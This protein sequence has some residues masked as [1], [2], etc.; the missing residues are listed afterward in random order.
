MWVRGQQVISKNEVRLHCLS[1]RRSRRYAHILPFR[2]PLRLLST[3]E[4]KQKFCSFSEKEFCCLAC[5]SGEASAFTPAAMP[6]LQRRGSTSVCMAAGP[7]YL[8]SLG[9]VAAAPAAAKVSVPFDPK[10]LLR[11][12][13]SAG[14][15]SKPAA[16]KTQVKKKI[17]LLTFLVQKYKY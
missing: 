6:A 17:S 15:E 7:P 12:P 4:G 13:W 8:D 14:S 10:E 3:L 5:Y 11:V 2:Y 16:A 1:R 9:S